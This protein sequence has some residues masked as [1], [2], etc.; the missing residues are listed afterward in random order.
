MQ[1]QNALP[2]VL[3]PIRIDLN[4]Q[5]FRPDPPLPTP[6]NFREF[7]IDETLPAYKQPEQTPEFRLKDAQPTPTLSRDHSATPAPLTNGVPSFLNGAFRSGTQ[8]PAPDTPAPQTTSAPLVEKVTATAQFLPTEDIHNPDDTY[9]CVINLSI[10]L[11]NRL[12]SDKFE[13][14]LLHPPGFAEAF[15]KQTCADVGLA[16]EWVPSMA[17]AIYEAIFEYGKYWRPST[18]KRLYGW[19]TADGQGREE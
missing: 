19:G 9:R 17:H 15:A 11:L 10:N 5:P 8:T 13:W 7:G 14:S 12:Y 4:V 6:H 16:G 18:A 1:I 2:L 3:I